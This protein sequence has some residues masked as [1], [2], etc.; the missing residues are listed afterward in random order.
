LHPIS[1]PV[2]EELV[3]PEEEEGLNSSRNGNCNLYC[4]AVVDDPIVDRLREDR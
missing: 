3:A 1:G 2:L 4:I